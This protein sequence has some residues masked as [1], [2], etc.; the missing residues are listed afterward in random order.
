MAM[1]YK[2]RRFWRVVTCAAGVTMA[3]G[4][5]FAGQVVLDGTVGPAGARLG[6]NFVI[7]QSVGRLQG[8]NLFHS[9]S[10]FNISAGESATFT[11][12]TGTAVTNVIAR[13]TG[14]SSSNI[15]GLVR[16]DIPNANLFLINPNG[17]VF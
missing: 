16:S 14:T 13:V 6:P 8:T 17:I 2:C 15:N 9:F 7:P 12:N 3:A 10:Q 4:H 1:K 5:A 11:A